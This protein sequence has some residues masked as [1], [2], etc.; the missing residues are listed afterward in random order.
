MQPR[1]KFTQGSHYTIKAI[2]K[3]NMLNRFREGYPRNG[4]NQKDLKNLKS[5]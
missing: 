5:R 4:Y 3:L 2:S 1:N